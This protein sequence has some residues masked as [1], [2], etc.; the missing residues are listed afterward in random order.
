M[1]TTDIAVREENGRARAMGFGWQ[2]TT[3]LGT[4]L[5]RSGYFQD[6]RDM[7]QAVVKVLAGRELGFGPI[8]SM[9]GVYI[10]KGRVTLSANLMAASIKRSGKYDYRI[11]EHTPTAC[12]LEFFQR[13][14][15]GWESLGESAFTAEDAKAAGLAGDAWRHYPRN[16]VFS[17][18]LSNGAKWYCPDVFG[19]PVYT[20]DELGGRIDGETGEL[21]ERPADERIAPLPSATVLFDAPATTEKPGRSYEPFGAIT[22]VTKLAGGSFDPAKLEGYFG[23]GIRSKSKLEEMKAKEPDLFREGY[24]RLHYDLWMVRP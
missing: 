17:R 20:P 14:E 3:D 4:L 24:D 11:R 16:M 9:T 12:K 21:I 23:A 1:A 15:A 13:V 8:A 7:A 19:G 2:E 5:A 6:A 10:V 22:M 18:A